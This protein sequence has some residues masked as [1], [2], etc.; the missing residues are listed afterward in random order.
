MAPAGISS[1]PVWEDGDPALSQPDG[2]VLAPTPGDRLRFLKPKKAALPEPAIP[3]PTRPKPALPKSASPKK[4]VAPQ[5]TATSAAG[6][7]PDEKADFLCDDAPEGMT[8]PVPPP[9]DRWLVRVCSRQGQALVPVMGM[10]WVAHGTS[11]I[12]SILALPPGQTARPASASFNPRY[13]Y[14]FTELA[15]GKAEGERLK[16][17]LSLLSAAAGDEKIQSPDEVWQLDAQSNIG[18]TRYNLFFYLR[19]SAPV[20]MIACLDRCR[21]ALFLDVLKGEA[22]R[23]AASAGKS[24][25]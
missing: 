1:S 14:R 19:D 15:G 11:D 16:D 12:A 23:L 24:G 3:A 18:K 17:A 9:F 21:Q 5:N 20:H 7:K 22:A 10:A 25:Q 13:A 6:K 2:E 4:V 8:V